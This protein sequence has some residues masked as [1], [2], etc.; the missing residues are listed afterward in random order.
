[1]ERKRRKIVRKFSGEQ[2]NKKE[3]HFD[4]KGSERV[5][6]LEQN[7]RGDAQGKERNSGKWKKGEMRKEKEILKKGSEVSE[8]N[9]K[10]I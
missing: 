7:M 10:R 5:L 3:G 8:E 9:Q 4:T 6:C 2:R 1:M